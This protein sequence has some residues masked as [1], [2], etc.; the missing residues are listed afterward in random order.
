VLIIMMPFIIDLIQ[1]LG[2]SVLKAKNLFKFRTILLISVAVGNIFLSIPAIYY[3]GKIGTAFVTACSLFIGNVVIMNIYYY[4]KIKLDI[5]S[6]WKAIGRLA[7]PFGLAISLIKLLWLVTNPTITW[8]SIA[9]YIFYYSV[10]VG[11]SLLCIGLK[12]EMRKRWL[13]QLKVIYLNK[14]GAKFW[15]PKS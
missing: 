12:K 10:I 11:V 7:I 8:F 15:N 1:N 13:A 9:L 4:K 6:F 14:G 3:Y 2:L 5:Y